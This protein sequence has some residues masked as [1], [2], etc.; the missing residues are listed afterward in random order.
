MTFT[1]TDNSKSKIKLAVEF[2]RS[3]V[4]DSIEKIFYLQYFCKR[5]SGRNYPWGIWL[6]E[7]ELAIILRAGNI[8]LGFFI[9]KIAIKAMDVDE[10]I[11]RH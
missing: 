2:G 3:R 4:E 6:C 9:I 11:H 10:I 1:E 8:Y 5:K 7:S